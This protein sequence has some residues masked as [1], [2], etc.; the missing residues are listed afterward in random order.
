MKIVFPTIA[1]LL[2]AAQAMAQVSGC[3]DPLSSNY[4]P[5]AT[6]ND[7][8]CTYASA[9][10]SATASVEMPDTVDESSGLIIWN[11]GVYTQ[12]DDGDTH[13]YR[14]SPANGEIT[15]TLNVAGTINQDWEDISQDDAYVYVGDFGN[16]VN[17]NRTNLH[18]LKTAKTGLLAGNPMIEN[19]NF[20]YANQTSLAATGNNNTDFDCE[21]MVVGNTYIYLFT[22][23]WVSK[24]TSVYRLP[25]TPGTYVAELLDTFNV[26]GLIT[27]ATLLEGQKLVALCGYSTTLS[28]FI[29]LLYDYEDEDFFGGNKRKLS[30][31]EL[32][33]QVEGI[34]TANG[35][36][37][38]L[39]CEHFQQAVLINTPQQLFT[40]N[41]NNYLG[42]YLAN[43]AVED[44]ANDILLYPNPADYTVRIVVKPKYIGRQFTIVNSTGQTVQAGTFNS[45]ENLVDISALEAGLY[46]V[47]V[48]ELTNALKLIVE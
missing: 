34:A 43:P 19:I 28:P 25:K 4:N 5:N 2:F 36:D 27:G 23:Q 7:G 48:T 21:A 12:N 32:F 15:Q 31:S 42:A 45:E 46:M 37:Y 9:S 41:L 40:V 22:K 39:S 47:T 10:V 11:D 26:N 18:I 3:T 6:V 16:N 24:Q 44:T 33:T 38:Y 13:L 14:M 30:F 29:Y 8:S 1:L 20:T 35:T 17:G